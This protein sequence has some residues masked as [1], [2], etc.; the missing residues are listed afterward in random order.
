M[1]KTTCLFLS[2]LLITTP[3]LAIKKA[4][5]DKNGKKIGYID[6][7]FEDGCHYI[8]NYDRGGGFIG[9]TKEDPY[10]KTSSQ[11]KIELDNLINA[12]PK[13]GSLE[14]ELQKALNTP[15]K[16]TN[17][18]NS[19]S[20]ASNKID[21]TICFFCSKKFLDTDQRDTDSYGKNYCRPKCQRHKDYDRELRNLLLGLT[22]MILGTLWI[23][24]SN[25]FGWLF[26]V[27]E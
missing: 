14:Y 19:S 21:P 20:T 5:Y 6:E 17:S 15:R 18:S 9:K 4:I 22:G 11:R 25:F 3:L 7:V 27:E 2:L 12:K 13:K 16:S 1:K 23:I 8:Y 26:D 10:C 24:D